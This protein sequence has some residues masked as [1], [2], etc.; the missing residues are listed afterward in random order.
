MSKRSAYVIQQKC[1][2]LRQSCELPDCNTRVAKSRNINGNLRIYKHTR[3]KLV[4]VFV[5]N[6]ERLFN[7]LPYFLTQ[8]CNSAELNCG[9]S[10][11]NTTYLITCHCAFVQYYTLHN[12]HAY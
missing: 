4:F 3:Q 7:F 8:H 1:Q 9:K 11:V 10:V 2:I 5:M 12:S 6:Q